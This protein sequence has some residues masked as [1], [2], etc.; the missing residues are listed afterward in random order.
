MGCIHLVITKIFEGKNLYLTCLLLYPQACSL[1]L[2]N[3]CWMNGARTMARYV[4]D[5]REATQ[6]DGKAMGFAVTPSGSNPCSG[7]HFLFWKM[8]LNDARLIGRLRWFYLLVK[9]RAWHQD[10]AGAEQALLICL[11]LRV[12]DCASPGGLSQ[13][14]KMLEKQGLPVFTFRRGSLLPGGENCVCL[15]H[16]INLFSG[17]TPGTGNW[18]ASAPVAAGSSY[19]YS[20]DL[21]RI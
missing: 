2:I 16:V 11:L 8:G 19:S 5:A 10:S 6:Y 20:P 17:H 1:P 14:G 12:L 9:C 18:K 13:A 21:R 3:M 7:L 4:L 15:R